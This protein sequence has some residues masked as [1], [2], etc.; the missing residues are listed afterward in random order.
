MRDEVIEVLDEIRPALQRDGGD[1]KFIDVTEDGVVKVELQGSCSGCPFSQMT[2]KN[3]IE[4]ELKNKIPE[5]KAVV[6][7]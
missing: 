3:L 5:V 2:V 4:T 1:V 6:G 7:V